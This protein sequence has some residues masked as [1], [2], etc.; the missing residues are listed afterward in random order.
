MKAKEKGNVVCVSILRDL[1]DQVFFICDN[2]S[3]MMLIVGAAK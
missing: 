3:Q 2:L 1:V